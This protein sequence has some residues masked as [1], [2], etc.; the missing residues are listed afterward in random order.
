MAEEVKRGRIMDII[1]SEVGFIIMVASI[2]ISIV[3][4]IVVPQYDGRK[5]IALILQ[6]IDTIETNHLVHLQAGIDESKTK[7]KELE[8]AINEININMA[9]IKTLLLQTH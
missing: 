1:K 5:D 6:K 2:A 3:M 8:V 4:F 9:E 7:N